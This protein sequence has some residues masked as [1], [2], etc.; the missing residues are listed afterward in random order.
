MQQYMLMGYIWE[1]VLFFWTSQFL[2][3]FH[4]AGSISI[5]PTPRSYIDSAVKYCEKKGNEQLIK[6]QDCK[7]LVTTIYVLTSGIASDQKK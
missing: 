5:A 2:H 7:W 3:I 4:P 1:H 6:P